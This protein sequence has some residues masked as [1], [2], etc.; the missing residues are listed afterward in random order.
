[1]HYESIIGYL[2]TNHLRHAMAGNSGSQPYHGLAAWLT[3]VIYD[4][5]YEI[6]IQ[7]SGL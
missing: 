1:M 4:K 5:I 3:E 7:K 2:E 6:H